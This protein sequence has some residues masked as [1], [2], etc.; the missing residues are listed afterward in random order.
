MLLSFKGRLP[1]RSAHLKLSKCLH[2]LG[3][4]SVSTLLL[5]I[6]LVLPVCSKTGYASKLLCLLLVL[7]LCSLCPILQYQALSEPQS[8]APMLIVLSLFIV[9]FLLPILNSYPVPTLCSLSYRTLWL[10]LCVT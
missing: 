8:L 7:F 4:N 5:T 6:S 9:S 10:P 2:C 3:A 1:P